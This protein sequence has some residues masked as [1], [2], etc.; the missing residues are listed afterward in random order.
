MQTTVKLLGGMQSNY[1]GGCSQIIGGYINPPF[2]PSPRVLAPLAASRLSLFFI[3]VVSQIVEDLMVEVLISE[4][5]G[6]TSVEAAG[7]HRQN[8]ER[9]RELSDEF[10]IGDDVEIRRSKTQSYVK[11]VY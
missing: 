5:I 1:W 10:D 9:N 2:P 7:P 3:F 11:Y 6:I 8:R 4:P